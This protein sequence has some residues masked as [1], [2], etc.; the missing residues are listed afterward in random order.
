MRLAVAEETPEARRLSVNRLKKTV[1]TPRITARKVHKDDVTFD[2]THSL[3]LST[4]YRPL[5]EETDRGTWRRLSLVRFPFTF[6]TD[7]NKKLISPLDKRG[8]PTLRDRAKLD[9]EIWAAALVWMIEGAMRWYAR[10]RI[11]P[12][13]PARVEAD[14]NEWRKESDQVLAY[15]DDRIRFDTDRH[16]M[17]SDFLYDLNAWLK[18]RGHQPWSDKLLTARFGDHDVIGRHHVEK[19]T[20]YQSEALSRPEGKRYPEVPKRYTAW[21]GIRFVTDQDLNDDPDPNK[22]DESTTAEEDGKAGKADQKLP[23]SRVQE[24]VS[25]D[26]YQPYHPPEQDPDPPPAV[27]CPR[28]DGTTLYDPDVSDRR[29]CVSGIR[30]KGNPCQ[31]SRK[32]KTSTVTLDPKG[33]VKLVKS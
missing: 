15:L 4:N 18:A 27:L 7:P 20:V 13:P 11:L 22:G 29:V 3:M 1:G 2:A 31:W 26:P 21:L 5:V 14:T 9:P 8:D 24:E 10:G 19:K 6:I 25:G 16:V 12:P 28:C 30:I 17:S 33:R 23:Q 32:E